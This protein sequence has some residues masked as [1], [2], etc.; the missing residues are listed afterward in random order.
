MGLNEERFL[1]IPSQT[2]SK[3]TRLQSWT[4]T[5]IEDLPQLSSGLGRDQPLTVPSSAGAQGCSI[6]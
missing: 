5:G 3:A 1:S 6:I 4:D 2:W